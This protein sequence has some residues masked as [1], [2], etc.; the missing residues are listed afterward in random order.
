MWSLP[1]LQALATINAHLRSLQFGQAPS[2]KLL[3]KELQR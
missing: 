1:L 2:Y 3:R